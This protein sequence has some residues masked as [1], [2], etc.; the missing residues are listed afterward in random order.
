MGP[1]S[2]TERATCFHVD[3]NGVLSLACA[4]VPGLVRAALV[5]MPEGVLLGGLGDGGT[6]ECEPLA[7]T[8]ARCVK[9]EQV[10]LGDGACA[11]GTEFV[12]VGQDAVVVVAGGRAEP[13]LALAVACNREPNLALVVSSTRAALS[14]MEKAMD[15]ASLEL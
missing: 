11:R 5:L 10:P 1:R 9:L 8:A 4:H 13:R 15:V 2:G 3:V 14:N 7:R 6:F 12:F